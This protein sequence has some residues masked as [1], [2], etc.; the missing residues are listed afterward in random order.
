VG[1][2]VEP[3]HILAMANRLDG[4]LGG[5]DAQGQNL[6][7]FLTVGGWEN[8]EV[9]RLLDLATNS[10]QTQVLAVLNRFRPVNTEELFEKA[11]QHLRSHALPELDEALTKLNTGNTNPEKLEGLKE[12]RI[13]TDPTSQPEKIAEA[14]KRYDQ[15]LKAR[16]TI[17]LNDLVR[18]AGE[19]AA[20]DSNYLATATSLVKEARDLDPSEEK[21]AQL[22]KLYLAQIAKHL[23]HGPDPFEREAYFKALQSLCQTAQDDKLQDDLIVIALAE[24]AAE[25]TGNVLSSVREK[26]DQI[27][28]TKGP[29]AEQPPGLKNYEKYVRL[30]V[31]EKSG[32]LK[33][34]DNGDLASDLVEVA[35]SAV[36]QP[37]LGLTLEYRQG[38]VADFLI[39]SAQA[40]RVKPA[41][42]AAPLEAIISPYGPKGS[43]RAAT[44][45]ERLELAKHLM[46]KAKDPRNRA[47]SS[48]ALFA[49]LALA[50]SNRPATTGPA[51]DKDFEDLQKILG[52]LLNN[53]SKLKREDALAVLYV[54]S[55]PPTTTLALKS[56][57]DLIEE[58]ST[59]NSRPSDAEAVAIY[60]SLVA[61]ALAEAKETP[62]DAALNEQI[63]RLNFQKCHLIR[64]NP[65]AEWPFT[66]RPAEALTAI[67]IATRLEPNNPDYLVE[68]GYAR[69]DKKP[70]ELA[71]ATADAQAA[72]AKDS[73]RA[74]AY[75]LA[76]KSLLRAARQE[77]KHA[78]AARLLEKSVQANEKAVEYAS[79]DSMR[80]FCLLDLGTSYVEWANFV[81]PKEKSPTELLNKAIESVKE[82]QKIDLD[83]YRDMALT[84]LGN[85]YEDLAWLNKKQDM[86]VVTANY[87]K[88]IE[89]FSEAI[90]ERSDLAAPRVDLGRCYYKRQ[91]ESGDT[92]QDFMSKAQASLEKAV[93]LDPNKKNPSARHWLGKVYLFQGKNAEAAAL[94][95]E[96]AQLARKAKSSDVP[97]YV[98]SL[99]QAR[100]TDET[101]KLTGERKKLAAEDALAIRTPVEELISTS[102]E[103]APENHAYQALLALALARTFE[104]EG[105]AAEALKIY[106]ANLPADLSLAE[107]FHVALLKAR[108]NLILTSS[109]ALGI[110]SFEIPL[111]DARRVI[112]LLP[113]KPDATAHHLAAWALQYQATAKLRELSAATKTEGTELLKAAV[114]EF[115][116][117]LALHE[118]SVLTPDFYSAYAYALS[119]LMSE[120][121]TVRT[122]EKPKALKA[123]N[124]AIRLAAGRSE[125]EKQV[126][127]RMKTQIESL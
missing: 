116:L 100:F 55:S 111:N 32:G 34:E 31:R 61:P 36:G 118:P 102:K 63:A 87:D 59:G 6:R 11:L 38:K 115:E 69:L 80:F 127:Q 17:L 39:Q 120:D 25:I 21:T 16:D 99:L 93:E 108:A 60:T 86:A 96:A 123:I 37:G 22:H 67:Q 90:D 42:G 117:A 13:L 7:T 9:E 33:L 109:R 126:L 95:N 3:D 27:A 64:D 53:R 14:L 101:K 28:S 75:A 52:V 124:E 20:R 110:K 24:C 19:L 78:A 73:K 85:A 48:N 79:D 2:G 45:Y 122:V 107:Q 54:S 50:M 23:D 26:V 43:D 98:E 51:A 71:L 77:S 15:W 41:E 47:A 10:T 49:N 30:V 1:A 74:R 4:L 70:P 72:I 92:S 97:V 29:D 62:S 105:N 125:R 68:R 103:D 81:D 83:S 66:D 113:N 57:A 91:A 40:L 104:L 76:G 35:K 89:S 8:Q 56:R 82:A 119:Q 5:A 46:E 94:L 121:P 65:T 112:A 44:A 58:L 12:L 88:A 106:N 84:R 114:K 18:V